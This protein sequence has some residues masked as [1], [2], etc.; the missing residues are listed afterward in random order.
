MRLGG[1]DEGNV[2]TDFFGGALQFSI[3]G[4]HRAFNII[5][6]AITKSPQKID[7]SAAGLD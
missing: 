3:N 7:I 5:D 1:L 6:D 4:C 2:P